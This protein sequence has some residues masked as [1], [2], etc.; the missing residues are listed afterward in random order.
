[1]KKIFGFLIIFVIAF[2]IPLN[3]L[4][5]EEPL[6][7]FSKAYQDYLYNL[8][9]YRDSY[10]EFSSAKEQ[11]STYK[12]LTAKTLVLEQTINMLQKRDETLKT[13]LTALRLKLAQSTGILN[14]EQN[15]LYLS[16]DN[17]VVWLNNHK[18]SLISVASLED[19]LEKSA[20]A[21]DQFP[22]IEILAYKALILDLSGQERKVLENIELQIQSAKEILKKVKNDNQKNTEII[23]RW[24]LEAE[25]KKTLGNEK[26]LLAKTTINSLKINERDKKGVYLEAQKLIKEGHQYLKEANSYLL[27][28]VNE[29]K[30]NE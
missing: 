20:I 29:I 24:L 26:I 3:A 5:Q 27:E 18:E 6:F 30:E 16:L 22:E 15:L 28:I 13:Y 1:M 12:T 19:V 7:D 14:Y 8:N 23:E 25:N 21:E 17:Q 4:A 2:F 10:Q 9:L 11:Y